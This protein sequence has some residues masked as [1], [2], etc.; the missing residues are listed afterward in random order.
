MATEGIETRQLVQTHFL[1]LMAPNGKDTKHLV[2]FRLE[3]LA[4][5]NGFSAEVYVRSL[6]LRKAKNPEWPL[7]GI[8]GADRFEWFM[9]T[10]QGAGGDT[11]EKALE[12][13]KQ[14]CEAL[15]KYPV[16]DTSDET[17]PAP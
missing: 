6:N 1:Q 8:G 5:G 15:T 17:K 13:G 2:H 12:A 4:V 14:A 7:P 11:L 10:G 3:I 16:T 9:V